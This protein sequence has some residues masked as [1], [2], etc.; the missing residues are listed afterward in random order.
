MGPAGKAMSRMC[1]KR[2][3]KADRSFPYA[4]LWDHRHLRMVGASHSNCRAPEGLFPCTPSVGQCSSISWLPGE[5]K[6]RNVAQ[7]Q[8]TVSPHPPPALRCGPRRAEAQRLLRRW[9]MG[10]LRSVFTSV[11]KGD[12]V[13]QRLDHHPALCQLQE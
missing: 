5:S 8:G 1:P 2:T 12:H 4:C 7:P 10:V 13:C 6:P 9:W 11:R 3:A